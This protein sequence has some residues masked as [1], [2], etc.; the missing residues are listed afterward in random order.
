MVIKADRSD[1]ADPNTIVSSHFE[2]RNYFSNEHARIVLLGN[3]MN[4]E[5]P[6]EELCKKFE[7]SKNLNTIALQRLHRKFYFE[8]LTIVLN[9]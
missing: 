2:T 3:I 9:Y 1:A 6:A 5:K 8:K 7:R 4:T